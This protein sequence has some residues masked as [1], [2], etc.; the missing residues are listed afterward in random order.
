MTDARIYLLCNNS[1]NNNRLTCDEWA[2]SHDPRRILLTEAEMVR[3]NGKMWSRDREWERERGKNS[4]KAS[5]FAERSDVV[6]L[7]SGCPAISWYGNRKPSREFKCLAWKLYA[8]EVFI[9]ILRMQLFSICQL[10]W[11]SQHHWRTYFTQREHIRISIGIHNNIYC[12]HIMVAVRFRPMRHRMQSHCLGARPHSSASYS[13]FT[14][15]FHHRHHRKRFSFFFSFLKSEQCKW[16]IYGGKS[17]F[18]VYFIH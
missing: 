6:A 4:E 18:L 16:W 15:W 10:N 17:R 13:L 8:S 5:I 11:N 7:R 9:Q 1:N 3:L 12:R 2:V 14:H